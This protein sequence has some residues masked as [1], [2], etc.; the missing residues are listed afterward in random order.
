MPPKNLRQQFFVCVYNEWQG[1]D[2]T[3]DIIRLRDA[4]IRD[5]EGSQFLE[6]L[7]RDSGAIRK[8]LISSGEYRIKTPKGTILIQSSPGND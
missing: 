7:R 1:E 5:N 3:N 2:V 8:S 4:L 6:R